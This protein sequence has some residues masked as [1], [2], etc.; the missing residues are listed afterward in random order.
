MMQ[1]LHTLQMH[2]FHETAERLHSSPSTGLGGTITKDTCHADSAGEVEPTCD[3]PSNVA[4]F[5][6]TSQIPLEEVDDEP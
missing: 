5:G 2:N 1:W 4:S 3:P 6:V